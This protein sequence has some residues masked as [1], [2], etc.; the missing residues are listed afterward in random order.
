M[1]TKREKVVTY[2]YKD[3]DDND[4]AVKVT[5]KEDGITVIEVPSKQFDSV[6]IKPDPKASHLF[7]VELTTTRK[8][9]GDFNGIFTDYYRLMNSVITYL[10]NREPTKTKRVRDNWEKNH[11][12]G[13]SK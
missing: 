13:A 11:A 8:P 7:T 3:K 12:A 1:S 5:E 9:I 2:N 10:I 4:V 6:S